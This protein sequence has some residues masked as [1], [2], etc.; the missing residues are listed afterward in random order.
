MKSKI[1]IFGTKEWADETINC[2]DG[3]EHRCRYCYATWNAVRFNRCTHD[4]WGKDYYKV[5]LKA[6]E[7]PAKKLN[8][9]TVMFPSSHDITP[10]FLSECLK[11][12]EKNLRVGNSCHKIYG[13]LG[14]HREL[15]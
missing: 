12:I 10:K 8:G 5:R 9:G 1:K 11:V 6:V 14:E 4:E 15:F 13:N 2:V 7:K 3:C